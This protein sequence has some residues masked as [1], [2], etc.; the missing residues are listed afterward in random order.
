MGDA[1]GNLC[2]KYYLEV[3]GSNEN[4]VYITGWHNWIMKRSWSD[5]EPFGVHFE[6]TLKM[7]F[8]IASLYKKLEVYDTIE[9][10]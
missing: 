9:I 3:M 5:S 2:T 4:A 1:V 8:M 7:R 6:W 10:W